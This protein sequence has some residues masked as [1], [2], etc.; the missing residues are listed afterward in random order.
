MKIALITL[1]PN[2]F[3]AITEHG[4]SGRAVKNGLVEIA[5]FNP[6]DFTEDR[7]RTVD[8]RPY[9][10]GPGMVMLIE[11][12]RKAIAAAREWIDQDVTVVYLSPQGQLL[13]QASVNEFSKKEN[14]IL[15]AGRYEGIDERLINLEVDE[16]WSIGDYVLSGGELPAMV[17]VDA[18]IRQKPGALGHQESAEQDSFAKGLLDCPHYTRPEVCGEESVPAVLLSGNHQNIKRWRMRQALLRTQLRRPDLLDG[19]ELD[20]EQQAIL[21]E[22]STAL[23]DDGKG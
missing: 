15:I 8:D 16:E 11:P 22:S 20:E 21:K 3:E 7:H 12:L 10:G 18:L 6:R 4:I 14:L 19:L 17:L 2:M 13:N 5:C 23:T 1:F 9:G